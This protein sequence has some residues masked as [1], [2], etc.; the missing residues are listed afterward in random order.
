[1]QDGDEYDKNSE[2]VHPMVLDE[3]YVEIDLQ[4]HKINNRTTDK[5]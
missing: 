1:M 2:R 5:V 4:T 3:D